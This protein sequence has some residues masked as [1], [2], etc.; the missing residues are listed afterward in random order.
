MPPAKGPPVQH[1][2]SSAPPIS[3]SQMNGGRIGSSG[4]M[5]PPTMSSIHSYSGPTE[6]SQSQY[7][8]Q[9]IS[10]GRQQPTFAQP[11]KLDGP[12]S[13]QPSLQLPP[14]PTIH[15]SSML[16]NNSGSMMPPSV[17]SILKMMTSTVD[18][19]SAI[20]PTPRT[21]VVENH[22]TRAPK[23]MALPPL[24]CQAPCK[25][26]VLLQLRYF[27]YNCFLQYL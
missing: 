7:M 22:P 10:N 13:H 6:K 25:C 21:D 26:N 27:F 3:S 2:Q 5:P 8:S 20:A 11:I 18:P 15:K 19:L 16:G 23:Y 4:Q 12:P 14:P 24:F 9:P 1:S 17:D